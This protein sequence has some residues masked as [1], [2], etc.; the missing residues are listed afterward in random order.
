MQ[1]RKQKAEPPALGLKP[2]VQ[3][4]LT[5][6]NV[7]F[8][9]LAGS[10]S[11]RSRTTTHPALSRA[12]PYARATSQSSIVDRTYPRVD[13]DDDLLAGGERKGGMGIEVTTEIMQMR[14]L[15]KSRRES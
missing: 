8:K 15:A 9:T 10:R 11:S 4:W 13:S 14:D 2:L 6:F 5:Y 12:E 7:H 1:E 3:V